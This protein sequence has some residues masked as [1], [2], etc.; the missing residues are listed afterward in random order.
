MQIT[1]DNNQRKAAPISVQ[2]FGC[3]CVPRYGNTPTSS[4]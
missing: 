1:A 3:G 4:I 2:Q